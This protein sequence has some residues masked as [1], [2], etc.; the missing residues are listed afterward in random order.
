MEGSIPEFVFRLIYYGI[1]GYSGP[2]GGSSTDC[3]TYR[4]SD[5]LQ[6]R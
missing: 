3:S 6:R 4:H 5:R 1:S 2:G